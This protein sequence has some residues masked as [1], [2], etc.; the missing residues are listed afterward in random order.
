MRGG[1]SATGSGRV[2]EEEGRD[3]VLVDGSVHDVVF[4]VDDH[5]IVENSC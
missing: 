5:N 2:A 3:D 4:V 1:K